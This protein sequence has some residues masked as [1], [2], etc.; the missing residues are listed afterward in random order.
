MVLGF[1]FW[2]PVGLALL[3]YGIW[4]RRMGF[5]GCGRYGASQGEWQA[6]Q[7]AGTGWVP[8]VGRMDELLVWR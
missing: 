1:I 7:L 5:W 2:W 4:S 6:Q 3:F 8:A